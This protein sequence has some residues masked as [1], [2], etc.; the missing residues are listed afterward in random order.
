MSTPLSLPQNLATQAHQLKTSKTAETQVTS[1][2]ILAEAHDI[3]QTDFKK[4][5]LTIQDLDELRLFQLAKRRDYEQQLNKNRLNY[6]QWMRYAKWEI[7]HNNDFK[8]A[9]SIFERALEVNVQHVP[10]WV[11]Y[12]ELELLHKNV[13]HARNLLDR[14]VTTM[15]RT[16]K[17]WFMFVQ[18]EETLSN[19]TGV[20]AV[21]ERWLQWKPSELA[22]DAYVQFE[23]RYGEFEN[24]RAIFLRYAT[25]FPIGATWKRW[26]VFETS[27]PAVDDTQ[28]AQ[29]RGVFEAALDTLLS[30]KNAPNDPLI[31]EIILLWVKWET[32][33][34]EIERARAIVTT[35][36]DQNLLLKDQKLEVLK[37]SA[38]FRELTNNTDLL[39][40]GES[41]L[42]LK[43]KLHLEKAVAENI[44]DYDSWWEYAKLQ[45]STLGPKYALDLLT[46]AVQTYPLDEFKL[47]SWRRYVFLW[48]KLALYHEY[49]IKD[50]DLAREVWTKCIKLLPHHKFT[51]AKV[52]T[53]FA[54]F[55]LRN[56]GGISQ[57]RKVL[58]QA[59]GQSCK[60]Q[61]KRKLF[62]YYI[63]LETRLGELERVRKVYE[64]WLESSLVYDKQKDDIQSTRVLQEYIDFERT[65]G[66]SERCVAL[67]DIGITDEFGAGSEFF[68]SYIE[69]LKE[70][71]RYE[72]AREV[73]R[74][75]LNKNNSQTWVQFALFES[76]ILSPTQ[77]DDLANADSEEVQ[78]QVEEYHLE[79]TRAIFLEGYTVFKS[80]GDGEKATAIIEA[81]LEYENM[82]GTSEHTEKVRAK[83]PKQ[84]TKRRSVDGVEEIYTEYEFPESA[85]N[86]SKFLAKAK[87][88]ASTTT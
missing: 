7:D 33:V 16:D 61:P 1:A 88:W 38:E 84:I 29:I 70:E 77:M 82:H 37:N 4:P 6:G 45:E 65:V 74:G 66:E 11:R 24:A 57:A 42:R 69:F 3:K 44:R 34:N 14:A 9:R 22:W 79:K 81:W 23:E 12:I 31:P 47:T 78:F 75:K 21:F 71:F 10:F 83:L 55:E 60:E 2:E 36:L 67:F 86:L 41:T 87:Q 54:E 80:A 63:G 28:V 35:V 39:D 19:F 5:S 43:K 52:W 68:D 40:S 64:K 59:I 48:I 46:K 51:F 17:F 72:K 85:P 20:R 32:S 49:L 8:R 13:N 18:T 27:I 26:L 76:S 62:T 15:P 56:G 30:N 53:M 25:E 50:V 73:F 58:G